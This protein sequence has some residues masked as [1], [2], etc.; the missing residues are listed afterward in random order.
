MS[1]RTTSIGGVISLLGAFLAS[2]L[3]L[4]LLAA[5]L[6]MPAVGATGAL[7]RSGVDVF[8]ELPSEFRTDPLAQTSQILASDGSVIATPQEQ[9][10][11]IVPLAKIAPIMREAQVAIED[12]RFYEHGGIDLQGTIRAVVSNLR[13]GSS[14]GAS[15]LTQ[16]YVKISLQYSALSAG[17]EEAAADAVKKDYMRKLK[18]LKYAITLEKKLSKDQILEGYLNLVYYGDRAY[19]VEAAAKH[20]F[21]VHASQLS[22]SQA[23]LLAGL[24]QNPGTTDPVNFPE[25]ALARR[26]VVLDRMHE[27]NRIT[28]KQWTD[29]KKRTLK[30]DMK[31][32]NPKSTCLASPYPYWCEFIINYAMTMPQLGKTVEER[33]RTLYRG[34]IT[35][36]TTL[37]PRVQRIAQAAINKKV[38]IG[39]DARIGAASY[40]ADPNTGQV[41]AFAQNTKY[42]V[43]KES[44]GQTGIGW[45]LDKKYGGSGGFQFG[46]TAKAFSLVTAMESGM[47]VNSSVD[48]K[49]AGGNSQATYTP[50][51]WPGGTANCGPG[52]TWKVF[53]DS[54][55]GGGKITLKEAT[56]K[57]TNTAFVALAEQLGG[58]KVRSTMLRL[59]LH[60]SDGQPIG[61][62]AP[63]YILGASDVSPQG[64]AHAYGVIAADGKKCPMVVVTKITKDGKDVALPKTKCDQVIEPDV[65]RATDKFLE[66]NMTNGSGIRNQ[67]SGGDR[68][69]AGKTGTANNNN[70]SWFVGYTPQLVTAV[71]VGTP[72]DPITRVM[73]NVRVGGQFYPVMHG[74]AI[75]APIWKQIMNGALQDAPIVKFKEP[76]EKYLKGSGSDIPG[77]VG[78]SVADAIA[79]L[80]AAGY[81]STVGG[82]MSS[83]VPSG[84]VAGT[85]PFGKAPAGTQITIYTSRGGTRQ[86]PAGQTNPQPNTQPTLY[87]PPAPGPGTPAKPGKPTKPPTGR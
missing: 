68:E 40:T 6:V 87:T 65:A 47:N 4:G 37:D 33:K 38:P 46:S 72:Y 8:N 27:L 69:S 85:S 41:L 64:V 35:I 15:S 43:D 5:G 9:N 86:A 23:A 52:G 26:N 80:S 21:S 58:C 28:D 44:R 78:M 1:S 42:T 22:L 67:L 7:A 10:R 20:Y 66:Y 34:G 31:V 25:R 70:E 11:T 82:S 18:E 79:T 54:P 30:Q 48:A 45:A 63:Q 3:V 55:F 29:A 53:N 19:G 62:Y 17:N 75:A 14:V 59:G 16:Q 61:R 83:G 73:K 39:N 2:A 32:T 71:W 77:V 84:L 57:S 36:R 51:D 50:K 74:A 76:A 12:H 24:T 49:A 81:P 56:A 60:Q 13:N